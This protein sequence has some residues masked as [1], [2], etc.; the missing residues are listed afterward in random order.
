MLILQLEQVNAP[1]HIVTLYAHRIDFVCFAVFFLQISILFTTKHL[2]SLFLVLFLLSTYIYY[3]QY[4][5]W[6]WFCLLYFHLS[7]P[8]TLLYL[9]IILWSVRKQ[10]YCFAVFSSCLFNE[11]RMRCGEMTGT[12]YVLRAFMFLFIY[13]FNVCICGHNESLSYSY[14]REKQQK[15]WICVGMAL[16]NPENIRQ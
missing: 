9:Y 3:P 4:V 16:F 10:C 14:G 12:I 11:W 5:C 8:Q 6:F 2:F 7:C 13:T 1:P 15:C